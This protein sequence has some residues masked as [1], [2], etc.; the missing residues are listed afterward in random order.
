MEDDHQYIASD[1]KF[2]CDGVIREWKVGL[3]GGG[4]NQAVQLQVWHPSNTHYSL[5]SEVTYTKTNGEMIAQVPASMTVSAGDVVGLYVPD[6]QL[7]P[8]WISKHGFNLYT[9][10]GGAQT[11]VVVVN[12]IASSPLITVVF[13]EYIH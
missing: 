1:L 5:I 3:E 4:N 2:E 11:S 9:I 10:Q 6:K 12:S 7:E 13:G 8:L